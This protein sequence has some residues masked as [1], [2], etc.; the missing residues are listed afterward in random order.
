MCEDGSVMPR[1]TKSCAWLPGQ[2]PT[3]LNPIDPII[4][5]KPYGIPTIKVINIG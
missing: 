2:C 1:D 4:P 5:T 3:D